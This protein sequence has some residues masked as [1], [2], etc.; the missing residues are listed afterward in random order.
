MNH[1]SI[2]VA[3][4]VSTSPTLETSISTSATST[5]TAAPAPSPAS[6][7]DRHARSLN[8]L[9]EQIF[10]ITVRHDSV[11]PNSATLTLVASSDS[12][13]TP[14]NLSE[15]IMMHVMDGSTIGDG[16]TSYFLACYKRYFA[17]ETTIS[18]K[19]RPDMQQ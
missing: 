10:L 4:E 7:Q 12:F 8:H 19:L 18:E 14:Q 6:L 9:L 15:L 3:P 1:S 5:P 2:A 11:T 13:I 16:A 17:K